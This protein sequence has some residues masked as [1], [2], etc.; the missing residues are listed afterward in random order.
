MV[1]RDGSA[2]Y[3]EAI[4][5]G[6]PHAVQ[7]SDRWHPWHNLAAAV[8][9]TVTANSR[10]W[11]TGPP[12]QT[13]SRAERTRAR[14]PAVHALL[15][16]GVGLLECARRLGWALNTVK[17]YAR[18]AT[19]EDLQRP[20]Q[21]ISRA[22]WSRPTCTPR[23]LCTPHVVHLVQ[24]ADPLAERRNPTPPLPTAG[25]PWPRSSRTPSGTRYRCRVAH[26]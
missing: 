6:A 13:G 5:Q 16:Q 1:C 9:K 11:H 26:R 24:P 18:A 10:C 23:V 3:A 8:E 14:H 21:R 2:A 20:A 17:R 12:R 4:R 7:V 19:A 22:I 25:G 15:D